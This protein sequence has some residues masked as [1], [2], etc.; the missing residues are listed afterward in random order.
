MVWTADG[1]LLPSAWEP[2]FLFAV[3]RPHQNGLLLSAFWDAAFDCGLVSFADDGTVLASPQVSQRA[4]AVLDLGNTQ[5]L[6]GLR[7]AH[8]ANLALHP[9]RNGF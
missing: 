6:T 4:C 5:R 2:L 8:P 9:A 1:T 3:R 7:D